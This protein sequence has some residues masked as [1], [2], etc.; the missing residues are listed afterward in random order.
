MQGENNNDTMNEKVQR[1]LSQAVSDALTVYDEYNTD[2]ATIAV[3]GRMMLVA[4]VHGLDGDP[5]LFPIYSPM[6]MW[7]AVGMLEVE[8]ER[9]RL[10]LV[11]N[12][13]RQ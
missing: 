9:L 13:K 2:D 10:Q 12:W 5:F 4:E 3:T 11:E 6:A 7:D 1:I 8:L